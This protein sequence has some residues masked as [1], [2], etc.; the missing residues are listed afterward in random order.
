MA[1]GSLQTAHTC[2]TA[3][4]G[5]LTINRHLEVCFT[6]LSWVTLATY[7]T[8]VLEIYHRSHEGNI[9][10]SDSTSRNRKTVVAFYLL[11]QIYKFT[12]VRLHC[13]LL[14]AHGKFPPETGWSVRHCCHQLPR[15]G[16][17]SYSQVSGSD[18]KY[19]DVSKRKSP[20]PS[21]SEGQ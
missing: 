13:T 19:S 14:L 10:L 12:N 15:A 6:L 9:S 7:D 18:H 1:R 11:Q 20:E 5:K 16:M 4:W 21:Y 8:Q 3:K 2:S 17:C